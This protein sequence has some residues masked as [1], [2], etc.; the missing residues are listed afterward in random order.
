MSTRQKP[1]LIDVPV[2]LIFWARP[3]PFSKVFEQVKK[4][5]PSKLFLYQDGPRENRPGDIDGIKKCRDIAEDI[6]WECK[7]HKMYQAKN[8]GC[9]PSMY[10][11]EKWAFSIVDECIV[12]EDDCVPSQ[13]LFPFCKELLEKYRY[14]ERI[15]MICG[16]NNTGVSEHCPH[17]YLFSTTGSIWGWA[18]WK[19]VIDTWDENYSFLDDKFT[20]K[21]LA[22]TYKDK[23]AFQRFIHSCIKHRESGKAHHETI[24]GASAFLNSR[25]NIVPTKNMISNIGVCKN[26]THCSVTDVKMLPRGIRKIFN[27]QTYEIEF[28]LKHPQYVIEDGE[29][30]KRLYRI[31]AYGH[32]FVRIFRRCEFIVL[33]LRYGGVKELW[34]AFLKKYVNK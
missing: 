2:V 17:S 24:L 19:R 27:M 26:A 1:Y 8:Y 18:S 15:N 14:D 33:R 22:E 4:A 3:E 10:I 25:F 12:L 13:S 23:N 6:D 16:M 32:P 30:R 20:I 9:D 31:M 5:R 29:F 11:A 28:P 34:R 7:V 21:Q